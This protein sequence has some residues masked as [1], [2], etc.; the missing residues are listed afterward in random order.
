MDQEFQHSYLE[1]TSQ[2]FP[3]KLSQANYSGISF[4]KHPEDINEGDLVT[5][6][7]Q[8]KASII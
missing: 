7:E 1:G 8:K 6:I 3:S 5:L 4:S 2:D